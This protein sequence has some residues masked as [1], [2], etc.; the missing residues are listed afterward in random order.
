MQTRPRTGRGESPTHT[1]AALPA[2]R[3]TPSPYPAGTTPTVVSCSA[4]QVWP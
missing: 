4:T 3:G 1:D 2:A